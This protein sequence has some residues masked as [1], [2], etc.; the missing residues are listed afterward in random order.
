MARKHGTSPAEFFRWKRHPFADTYPIKTPYAS[1]WDQFLLNSSEMLLAN[2][3]NF[4]LFGTSGAGKTTLIRHLLS[5]LDPNSYKPAFIHY[6]GLL[7]NGML[8]AIADLFGVDTSGRNVPLIIKLQKQIGNNS[9][10]RLSPFPVFIIDDAHLMEKESLMDI[11]SLLVN[12]H[13]EKI[14][15]SLIL[16]G[17]EKLPQRLRLQSM[18]SVRSRLTGLFEMKPLNHDDSVEFIEFRLENADAPEDLFDQ[19]TLHQIVA[20]CRGNRRRIMNICT[21][22]LNEAYYRQEK[23]VGAELFFSCD[24]IQISE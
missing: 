14:A 18:A 19:E 23:T 6:G 11:C 17:D 9:P 15:A 5:N 1:Q 8:K 7:R 4:A 22:L 16:V 24:Q 3:K 21:L 12:P 20:H 2:G 13:E 10:D